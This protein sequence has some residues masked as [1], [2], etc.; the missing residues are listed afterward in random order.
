MFYFLIP[1]L[2]EIIMRS[3]DYSMLAATLRGRKGGVKNRDNMTPE[4]LNVFKYSLGSWGMS[5]LLV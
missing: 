4:D 2:P 1:Y 3:N 5:L